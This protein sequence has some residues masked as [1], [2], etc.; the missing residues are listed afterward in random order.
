MNILLFLKESSTGLNVMDLLLA[1][2]STALQLS[3]ARP[4][5]G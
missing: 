4:K 2:F 1:C 3:G 5:G